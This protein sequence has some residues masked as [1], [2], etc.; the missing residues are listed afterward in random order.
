MRE[1][2]AAVARAVVQTLA[3]E[4]ERLAL[5]VR[6]LAH[7]LDEDPALDEDLAYFVGFVLVLADELDKNQA[8]FAE[9][10][11]DDPEVFVKTVRAPRTVS[12]QITGGP[13][14]AR[15]RGRQGPRRDHFISA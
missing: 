4:P 11:V 6:A 2:D 1:E 7:Q 3:D 14:K 12:P 9:L 15:G 5:V 8:A 13:E 10:V